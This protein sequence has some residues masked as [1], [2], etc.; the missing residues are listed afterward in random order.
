MDF[1]HQ[2]KDLYRIATLDNVIFWQH[3]GNDFEYRPNRLMIHDIPD[4]RDM[5]PLFSGITRNI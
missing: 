2:Q 4:I 1:L 5:I 3:T